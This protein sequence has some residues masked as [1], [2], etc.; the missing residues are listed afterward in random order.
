VIYIKGFDALS[1]AINDRSNIGTQLFCRTLRHISSGISPLAKV[2]LFPEFR[3]PGSRH[4]IHFQT[5]I[6]QRI[7]LTFTD[8][9]LGRLLYGNIFTAI[10]FRFNITDLA[11]WS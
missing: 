2:Q 3:L 10:F 6:S 9:C 8:A 11:E 7:F 5:C 4:L 1:A